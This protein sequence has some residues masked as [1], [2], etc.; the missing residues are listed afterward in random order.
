MSKRKCLSEKEL[1]EVVNNDDTIVSDYCDDSYDSDM[2]FGI[3]NRPISSESKE[4]DSADEEERENN[5]QYNIHTGLSYWISRPKCQNLRT[6]K[7]AGIFQA[8]DYV[9]NLCTN[10]KRN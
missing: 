9:G 2:S 7:P 3:I 6:Q 1:E 5:F 8:I 4:A 10:K